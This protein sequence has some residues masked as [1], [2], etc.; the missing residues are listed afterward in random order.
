MISSLQVVAHFLNLYFSKHY[1]VQFLAK[2]WASTAN[3]KGMGVL[4]TF[5]QSQ[6]DSTFQHNSSI[7]QPKYHTKKFV[8]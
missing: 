1:Y 8:L 7:F 6:N 4:R 3:I 5:R 2:L